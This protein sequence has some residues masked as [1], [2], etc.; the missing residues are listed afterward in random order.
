[1]SSEGSEAKKQIER[2]YFGRLITDDSPRQHRVSFDVSDTSL[3]HI[4]PGVVNVNLKQTE[5]AV[6]RRY[7]RD[8]DHG[9]SSRASD[10][11]MDNTGSQIS[12]G[13][14]GYTMWQKEVVS[15][16]ALSPFHLAVC[17]QQR[18]NSHLQRADGGG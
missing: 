5:D 14:P 11:K 18:L 16:T 1:M 7:I 2:G 12:R 13:F 4:T 9:D 10:L 6:K 3:N 15:R 17:N 8:S